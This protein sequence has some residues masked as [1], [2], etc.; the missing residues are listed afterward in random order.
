MNKWSTGFLFYF[1]A[2]PIAGHFGLEVLMKSSELEE[3]LN[4][5]DYDM[6]LNPRTVPAISFPAKNMPIILP[7]Y[8][9]H[10]KIQMFEELTSGNFIDYLYSCL[11]NTD[12]RWCGKCGKCVRISKYCE[13]LGFDK[14]LIGMQEGI[15]GKREK[16][17]ISRNYWMIMDNLY[18]KK[19]SFV[20]KL[21]RK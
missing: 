15:K 7:A 20:S 21:F 11:K 1:L 10:S 13:I 9:G 3:A 17:P 6:S 18:S 5:S 2:L 4:F 8:N 14:S 19:K 12:K 16:S